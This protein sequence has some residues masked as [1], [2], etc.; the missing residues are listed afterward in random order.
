MFELESL[1]EVLAAV[2]DEEGLAVIAVNGRGNVSY[3]STGARDVFGKS[4]AAVLAQP[5][6]QLAPHAEYVFADLLGEAAQGGFP[7]PV[8]VRVDRPD[9]TPFSL[10]VRAVPARAPGE[11]CVVMA[12]A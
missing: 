9:G 5:I 7:S 11:G 4:A 6:S 10:R 8:E 3:W 2:C 1:V 12:R